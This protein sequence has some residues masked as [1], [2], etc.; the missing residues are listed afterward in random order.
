VSPMML[1]DQPRTSVRR[2]A[3]IVV[4]GLVLCLFVLPTGLAHA[5]AYK[6]YSCQPPG[7]NIARPA[8]AP[9]RLYDE[10]NSGVQNLS[11][12]GSV[13]GGVMALGFPSNGIARPM[14]RVSFAGFELP[15]SELNANVAILRVK[16]WASSDLETMPY[17]QT[18]CP[19]C[20]QL[21]FAD[22]LGPNASTYPGGADAAYIAPAFAPP[23]PSYRMGLHC[24]D[25]AA[26]GPCNL[27]R[28]PNVTVSGTEVDLVE[29]ILPAA[30]IDGG[31]LAS[32][33]TKAGSTTL[34]YTAADAQ[35]GIQ[36][37][38]VLLDG[39]TAGA[40]DFS[41]DLTLPLA[42]QGNGACT[43]TALAA[44]PAAETGDVSVDTTKVA[45]GPHAVTLRVTDAAGNRKDVVGSMITVSNPGA[46]G[47]VASGAPNGSNASRL[48]KLT[49][50]FAG[51]RKPTFRVRF[52]SSPTIRGQLVDEHSRGIGG[53]SIAV[54]VRKKTAG[55]RR[56]QIN[57][58][59]T[60][61][62]GAFSY[63]LPAGPSRTVTFAYTAFGGD[64]NSA[65]SSS[66]RTTVPASLAVKSLPTSPGAGRSF[67]L[68]GRLRY[69]PRSGVRLLVQARNGG[70]WQ[71]VDSVKTIRGGRFS[72]RYRFSTAQRGRTF[73]FR[74][75]SDS[76]IYPFAATNSPVVRVR[77]RG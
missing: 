42:Q 64:A 69:L 5:G 70:R 50:R 66:L 40:Q 27:L 54:L 51:S 68:T 23:A 56:E 16:S 33:G 2:R 34:S 25:G 30:T 62:D 71:T 57:V 32:A 18:T 59:P 55:A 39:V 52:K 43:Y 22:G 58:V 13:A 7:L 12:C 41:R 3:A 49:T 38:D 15:A 47:G 76:E 21:T 11:N 60:G 20:S 36:R 72:W 73:A 29:S 63:R 31:S 65:V 77:V 45:D 46:G 61:A 6:I 26:G 24:G 10:N 37:V 8:M 53:A 44:C 4:F 17:D 1:T 75:R 28:A 48:A 14:N 35:S 19:G 74:V 67:R 9:W